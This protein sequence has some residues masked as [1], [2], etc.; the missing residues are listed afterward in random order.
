MSTRI[1]TDR[2]SRAPAAMGRAASGACAQIHST[3]AIEGLRW[4]VVSERDELRTLAPAWDDLCGPTAETL[5][6]AWVS[7]W[8]K[9]LGRAAT[10]YVLVAHDEAGRLC[11]VL[12]LARSSNGVVELAGAACGAG[13]GDLVFRSGLGHRIRP[14][15]RTLLA[16]WPFGRLRLR[17][18]S[19]DGSLLELL[20]SE[21]CAVAGTRQLSGA[22]PAVVGF[23]T[24]DAFLAHLSKHQRHEV[25][26]HLKRFAALP[27]A[28]VRWVADRED[29][30]PA[31]QALFR[32][33]G[34]R[35]ASQKRS[36]TFRGAALLEFH[37]RL[38]LVLHGEGRLLLGQLEI[39]DHP[40]AV[41][42]GWHRRGRTTLFQL[43]I[44]PA[45]QALGPG[46]V[47]AAH[48]LRDHV[49]GAGRR[50]LDLGE[51]CY[52]WKLGWANEVRHLVDLNLYGRGA[53]G[54][55]R[56]AWAGVVT[57]LR[58]KIGAYHYGRQ[59]HGHAMS[60]PKA[61]LCKRAGCPGGQ[62]VATKY[63]DGA[64]NTSA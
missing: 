19:A 9:T 57:T 29:V 59:C 39:A 58:S 53:W 41:A 56:R 62:A 47:L 18:L 60:V 38:A 61:V 11:A 17:R 63:E 5:A 49:I 25:R 27:D 2:T 54:R 40:I 50:A 15:L 37:R 36:T 12:P 28:H 4:S 46:K 35:F 42:Y 20:T 31:L 44:D 24:W 23:E 33:H 45:A 16:Q 8:F 3:V 32:L 7:T 52:D 6:P 1:T 21:E 51:G 26:R 55:V 30:E 34:E 10:P 43:G 48:V 13:D 22:A 64:R 14:G